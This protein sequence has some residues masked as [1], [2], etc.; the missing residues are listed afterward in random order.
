M[1]VA[2]ATFDGGAVLPG[3][4]PGGPPPDPDGQR[5]IGSLDGLGDGLRSMGARRICF[6]ICHD[7]VEAAGLGALLDEQLQGF[8]CVHFDAFTPN[9]TSGEAAAAARVAAGHDADTL[10]ALGGGSAIDVAKVAALACRMPD[11]I[12]AMARGEGV[13]AAD[14]A[15][16]VAI[17]TTSG[18]G[19]ESTHFAVI[20]VDGRKVSVA[21]P[22]LRP[23]AAVLDG[24]LHRAMPAR[25]AA[26]TGL[27]ALAQAM[28]SLWAVGSTERSAAQARQAGALIRRHLVPSVCSAARAHRDG[29][30]I[31]AHLAGR[32]INISKTTAAHAMS[33]QLTKRFGLPHGLA[34]V[35]TLGALAAQN[36]RT[37]ATDCIDPRGVEHVRSRT[38]DAAGFL[39]VEPAGL[40]VRIAGLLRDLGLPASLQ[41]A[42]V[43]RAALAELATTVDPVRLGNNP[44]RLTT[45]LLLELLERSWD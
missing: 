8:A 22:R 16:L 28:E 7:A 38:R 11:R 31:G 12:D 42:G 41:E 39:D 45:A 27:D 18:T 2:D 40:T 36:A 14:P 25:L 29:M 15:P 21:H 6:V 35:L 9:P 5:I 30:M 34:V 3:G 13:L 1:T 19:S 20:Y 32:A 26:V 23:T 44:R 17:P 37:G 43:P 24:R 4:G 33:Y 10:L